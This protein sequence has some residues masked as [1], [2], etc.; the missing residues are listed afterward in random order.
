MSLLSTGLMFM[1]LH[2]NCGVSLAYYWPQW[3]SFKT[4]YIS[5]EGRVIDPSNQ[6][7]TSEGQ[8]YALFFSLIAN[9]RSTFDKLLLWTEN[10]L[11]AG[12]LSRHLPGWQWGQQPDKAAWKLLDNNSATD[13]D[14]W[15]AYDL[16]EAGRLWGNKR[17]SQLGLSI[18][19]RITDEESVDIPGLG[20]TLLPGKVGFV[21]ADYWRLN[22]SYSP[23]HLLSYFASISPTWNAIAK[24]SQR[25]I[26]E[27]APKGFSPDW[28]RWQKNSGWQAD[29]ERPNLGSYDAI[30]VYLWAGMLATGRDKSLFIDTLQPMATVTKQQGF[31]PEK[32]NTATAETQGKGPLGFSAALLPLLQNQGPGLLEQRQRVYSSSL[33]ANDYYNSVLT[34]FGQGWDQH[35]YRFSAA[36]YLFPSWIPSCLN[37]AD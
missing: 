28:V 23:P 31:P 37:F 11:A 21:Q 27:T 7:T 34:L 6:T 30:R 33:Q 12:D 1:L 8:S 20:K 29:K 22:P 25:L 2:T 5:Q 16:L 19:K 18:L 4:H 14:M 36:G 24:T 10:N 13:A 17:Y 15:I 26:V 9:D 3:Q 32:V 35:R